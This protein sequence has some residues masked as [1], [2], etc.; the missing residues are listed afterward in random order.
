MTPNVFNERVAILEEK[1]RANEINHDEL[2]RKIDELDEIR[3][4]G[5]LIL[6]KLD[7]V[8][9]IITEFQSR[10]GLQ[11]DKIAALA[12]RAD[13]ID[14]ALAVIV[15]IAGAAGGAVGYALHW[16]GGLLFP[17]AK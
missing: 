5:K 2:A 7:D 1:S 14:G 15:A 9:V 10:F 11:D 6:A 12:R 13:K 17:A 4:N 8:R 16:L 3:A